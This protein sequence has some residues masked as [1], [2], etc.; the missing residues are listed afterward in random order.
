[1]FFSGRVSQSPILA[2]HQENQENVIRF[3]GF[4]LLFKTLIVKLPLCSPDCQTQE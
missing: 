4:S 3:L 1:M 2:Y